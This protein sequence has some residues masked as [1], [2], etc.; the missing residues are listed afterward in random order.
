VH[1]RA[2]RLSLLLTY[3]IAALGVGAALMHVSPVFALLLAAFV[4][5]GILWDIRDTHPLS[6]WLL[7][8]LSITGILI[9][10]AAPNGNGFIGRL[11]SASVVLLGG[12]LLA[13]KKARDQLQIM[14]LSLLLLIGAALLSLNLS[15]ALLFGLYLLLSTVA[16]IWMPFGSALGRA[17]IDPGFV[18]RVSLVG[19]GLVLASIPLVLVFF[20]ALPRASLPLWRG[21]APLSG[22]TT[23]FTDEVRLG[24]VGR[25]AESEEVAFRAEITSGNLPLPYTPYWRGL[26]FEDTDGIAWKKATEPS[27]ATGR[28]WLPSR[29]YPGGPEGP[30]PTETAAGISL[31]LESLT[32]EERRSPLAQRVTQTIY[33]EPLGTTALFGLDRPVEAHGGTTLGIAVWDGILQSGRAVTTRFRYEVTSQPSAWLPQALETGARARCLAV[34]ADL[35]SVVTITARE[36]AGAEKDPYQQTQLLLRHFQSG[37]YTYSLSGPG[38][39]GHPLQ[40]FLAGSRTGF[41]EHFASAMTLMLRTLGIPARMVGGYVGGEYNSSGHYYL[42]RQ[43]SAHVW[44]EAYLDGLGWLRLDPTPAGEAQAA[45]GATTS[46]G[47]ASG[48]IDSLRLKWFSLV[49]GYDL[50]RQFTLFHGLSQ[51]IGRGLAWRPSGDSVTAYLP[52]LFALLASI[53]GFVL[54]R[55]HTR[56]DPVSSLYGRLT[57]R[58]RRRGLERRPA[59]GFL[60]FAA[61]ASEA[62]PSAS[63]AIEA[64]TRLYVR[65]KYGAGPPDGAELRN[66]R[67]RFRRTR[68]V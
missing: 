51:K 46:L 52:F 28:P 45:S 25:I 27:N 34:P 12:K 39:N 43:H 60:A 3:V 64:V 58:L 18:K 44:V 40:E 20:L 14:L 2:D 61:R 32:A 67:A 55:T 53:A 37:A 57:R 41:C 59:E 26:V 24:D 54:W 47:G 62:V 68:F 21:I 22:M 5:L 8:F 42:V 17:R 66:V 33:L 65:N 15:F 11:L 10:L 9:A 56:R 13:A 63:E 48:F 49:I 16:L 36:V 35:P 50:N 1:L 4:F 19:G 31:P 30:P 23:G 6:T 7:N 29:P 38:G